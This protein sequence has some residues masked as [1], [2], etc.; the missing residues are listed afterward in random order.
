MLEYQ[1]PMLWGSL[2]PLSQSWFSRALCWRLTENGCGAIL[3]SEIG[4]KLLRGFRKSSLTLKKT[5]PGR[6]GPFAVCGHD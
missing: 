4:Q 6:G 5:Y 1:K 3:A 2:L